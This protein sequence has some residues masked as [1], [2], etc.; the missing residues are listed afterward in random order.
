MT[1]TKMMPTMIVERIVPGSALTRSQANVNAS[2]GEN[3]AGRPP[4]P[5]A[6][7]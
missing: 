6:P 1:E 7:G 3:A 4:P 5:G 2:P